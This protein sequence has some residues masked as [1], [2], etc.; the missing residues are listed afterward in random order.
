MVRINKNDNLEVLIMTQ[1]TINENNQFSL[2]R[3]SNIICE[4][5]YFTS[6]D[7]SLS[8]NIL[9][10]EI[11][12]KNPN[13]N[14][15]G[16]YLNRN[17]KLIY[18][19]LSLLNLHIP[20]VPIDINIPSERLSYIIDDC[21]INIIIT[22]SKFK[23][24]FTN[25]N[26]ICCDN[27]VSQ[28][29]NVLCVYE[30]SEIAYIMYTSGSTGTPKG[31]SIFRSSLINFITGMAN[32]I[33][34][35]NNIIC[36]TAPT[37]DIFFVESIMALV[38]GLTVIMANDVQ[39]RN[40]KLITELMLKNKVIN[41]QLT[42]SSLQMLYNF[43]KEF[44]AFKYCKN[45]LVGGEKFPVHLLKE[46]QL[47][48]TSKIFNMYGP[49]E[50]TIWSTIS[51]LTTS[52][53]I[54]IGRPILNTNIYLIDEFCNEVKKGDQGQI[55]IGGV[56]VAKEY[57]N[58]SDLTT[59]CFINVVNNGISE[60]VYTT[61]DLGQFLENGNLDYLGRIDNQVKFRGHRIE[62]EDIEN[63]I[64]SYNGISQSLVC[65][66]D[67]DDHDTLI[68]YYCSDINLDSNELNKF[69]LKKLPEYMIPSQFI[70]IDKF[71]LNS[72]GK[73]DRKKM[74]KLYLE[75]QKTNIKNHDTGDYTDLENKVIEIICNNVKSI[76]AANKDVSLSS[77]SIDS[78]T[79]IKIIVNLEQEFNFEFDDEKLLFN[80]FNTINDLIVYVQDKVNE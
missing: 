59:K 29:N 19:M 3:T 44:T 14:P 74:I 55:C 33:D 34:I 67:S 1:N 63:N 12:S 61:G 4:D 68:C 69:L 28:S 65:Y 64:N 73:I 60:R 54:D 20:Y 38:C 32:I 45:I 25:I 71:V 79:F 21:K 13:G 70:K 6:S 27:L 22:E 66:I 31:I 72:N 42:P 76:G 5:K 50:T 9:A 53:T 62:L 11:I 80:A 7:I 47:K 57:I 8:V 36:L 23:N 43:D 35:N 41:I 26:V 77:L 78:I 49:T 56:G 17:E 16:I 37:F 40:P 48:T 75:T 52:D 24:I 58:N 39:Y 18:A 51:D 30:K 15:I 2:Q 46:L 10:N